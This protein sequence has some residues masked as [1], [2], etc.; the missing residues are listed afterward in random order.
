MSIQVITLVWRK[1]P[2]GG[3]KLLTMLALADW[4]SDDGGRIYPS[5]ATLADKI[6]MSHRQTH[7][8][9]NEL[10]GDGWLENLTPENKGGRRGSNRYR[11]PIKTLTNC[12]SL[13]IGNPDKSDRNYDIATSL[14]YDTAV[15]HYPLDPLYN[16]ADA[17][18][19]PVE[20]DP[21]PVAAQRAF[22]KSLK[23]CPSADPRDIEQAEI[24]LEK[25]L[26]LYKPQQD[27]ELSQP[28][29]PENDRQTK[30]P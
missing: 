11:I 26:Q 1:F 4:A 22:L 24:S 18:S 9:I 12:Q 14:N 8:I 20:P 17:P 6:R 25:I 15:S 2:H 23:A 27:L 10:V 19:R 16:Q 29:T 5:I 28:E 7:R 13:E 3:A 21:P 30:T